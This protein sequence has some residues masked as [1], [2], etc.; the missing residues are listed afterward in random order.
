ML[1]FKEPSTRDLNIAREYAHSEGI[2]MDS[3]YS[4]DMIDPLTLLEGLGLTME[5][6][7]EKEVDNIVSFII[8]QGNDPHYDWKG[9]LTSP[10]PPVVVVDDTLVDGIHR[11]VAAVASKSLVKA[12]VFK[13]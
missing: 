13:K 1:I 7:L 8:S 9:L 3:S 5:P 2:T 11:C 10:V 12:I 4:L 6:C